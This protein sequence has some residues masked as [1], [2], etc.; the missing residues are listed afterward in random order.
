VSL[1]RAATQLVRAVALRKDRGA[2]RID[3]QVE[4]R[5]G[6]HR[7]IAAGDAGQP[8]RRIAWD[9][10]AEAAIVLADQPDPDWINEKCP[11]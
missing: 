7:R 10:G 2:V 11:G 8:D 1:A 3:A 5:P 9:F 6:E 4:R